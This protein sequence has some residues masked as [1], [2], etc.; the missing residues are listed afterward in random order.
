M[1]PRSAAAASQQGEAVR[2]VLPAAAL[3][4]AI[5]VSVWLVPGPFRPRPGLQRGQSGRMV[6]TD[7]S[8]LRS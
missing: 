7:R 4:T 5:P 1:R 2:A 3:I 6:G 8:A